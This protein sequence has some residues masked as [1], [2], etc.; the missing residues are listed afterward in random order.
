MKRTCWQQF[1]TDADDDDTQKI[2]GHERTGGRW[3]VTL[4]STLFESALEMAIKP[5]KAGRKKRLTG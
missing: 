3:E 1:L 5:K 2:P 4:F